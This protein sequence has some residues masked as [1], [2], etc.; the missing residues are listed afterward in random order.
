[1]QHL[2]VI[3]CLTEHVHIVLPYCTYIEREVKHFKHYSQIL[4]FGYK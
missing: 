4:L 2:L 1:M 3:Q